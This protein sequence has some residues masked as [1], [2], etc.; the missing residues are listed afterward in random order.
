MF[1]KTAKATSGTFE[2]GA[3]GTEPRKTTPKAASLIGADMT[4]DGGLTAEGEAHIDGV[5]RG[6]VRV[7]RLTIG[8]T[9][10][11]EGQIFADAVEIRGRVVGAVTAG[12]VRL[13]GAAHLDGDITHEQLSIEAG[14]FFQ[15]RS[16]RLQRAP[17][18]AVVAAALPSPEAAL[19]PAA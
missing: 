1:S 2:L 6:D 4:I 8:D 16:L 7:G 11:V 14:A 15:G 12:Q 3:G 9:G 13:L 19:E 18:A 5:V 10:R 17:A